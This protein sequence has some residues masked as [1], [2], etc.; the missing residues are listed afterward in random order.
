[1]K[2]LIAIS[3]F[4]FNKTDIDYYLVANP[5]VTPIASQLSDMFSTNFAVSLVDIREYPYDTALPLV[6][7]R[8]I[9]IL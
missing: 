5:N 2:T 3:I 4:N 7:V 9:K 8:D 6:K 1:M